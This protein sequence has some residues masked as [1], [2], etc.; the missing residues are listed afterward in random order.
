MENIQAFALGLSYSITDNDAFSFLEQ[1]PSLMNLD[2]RYYLAR[3]I[4]SEFM[5]ITYRWM[6]TA[7]TRSRNLT[8]AVTVEVTYSP[9]CQYL[10][11]V[12]W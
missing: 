9:S 11:Q 10:S 7:T 3:P 5:S 8:K 12:G 1:S 4:M 6:P 2:F